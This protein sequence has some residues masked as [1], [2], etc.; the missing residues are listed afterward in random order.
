MSAA[1]KIVPVEFSEPK[2]VALVVDDNDGFNRVLAEF[3]S[4]LGY[5]V[6]QCFDGDEATRLVR[7]EKFDIIFLDIRMPKV[8]GLQ[9]AAFARVSKQN[10]GSH[11]FIITGDVDPILKAKAE[12]LKIKNFMTKPLDF[13]QME[14]LVK[15]TH[16][17][18]K[19]PTNYDERVMNAFIEAAAEVY[20]FHFEEKPNRGKVQFRAPG[21][22]QKGFCTS[23]MPFKGEG[24]M[25]SMAL[26]MTASFVKRLALNLF[27]GVDVKFDNEFISDLSGEICN[28][29]MGRVKNNL[30]KFGLKMSLG[31]PD[32]IMGKNHT[33]QHKVENPIVCVAMGRDKMVFELQFALSY[34]EVKLQE[35]TTVHVPLPGITFID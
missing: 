29:I 31:L 22:S 21:E 35:K 14:A 25:G 10:R 32:V 6:K 5:A 7:E 9:V 33:I 11:I 8:S 34:Q 13:V 12:A 19:A 17:E 27:Q 30:D 26:S 3:L 1:E 16:V 24:F 4:Q 2:R 28:Q 23:L 15:A 18:K 20:E